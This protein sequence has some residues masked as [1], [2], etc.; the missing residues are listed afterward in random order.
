[1]MKNKVFVKDII[2]FL[3]NIG[4]VSVMGD[5]D[6]AYIDNLADMNNVNETTLDWVNP[7]KV[8][9]QEIVENSP[10]KVILVDNRDEYTDELKEKQKVL[11]L[12]SNPKVA[13]AKIGIEFFLEKI[14]PSIHP[15]AIV[16]PEAVLG[17]NI[18][19][20]PYTVIGKAKIGDN[21]VI[22]AHC[23]IYDCVT[24]GN[25]CFL[26]DGVKIGGPGFGF[27]IDKTGHRFRFPQIGKVIIG[28]HVE[29]GANSCI[30]RGALSNTIIGDHVKIDNLCQIAHNDEIGDDV[31][32]T[33]QSGLAGSVKIGNNVW[34]APNAVVNMGLKV[35]DNSLIGIG[36]SVMKNVKD[37]KV[38]FGN[39]A[40]VVCDREDYDNFK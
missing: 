16:D 33:A 38:C 6:F 40:K 5:Y 9:K 19:I 35:G 36:S 18:Y 26:K 7:M 10:A 12:V 24:M 21:C 17:K 23:R 14:E 39:P 37:G 15:T 2:A 4:S 31:F 27:E 3:S 25:N 13:L 34:I 11:I 32:I 22:N 29:I 28:N 20:G 8:N 30:D 1:M